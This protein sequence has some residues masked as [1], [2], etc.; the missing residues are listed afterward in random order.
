MAAE[1]LAVLE[2]DLAEVVMVINNGLLATPN[3]A[4]RPEVRQM[5]QRWCREETN[6]LKRLAE[7][8]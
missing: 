3:S 6:Y 2:R 7:D 8:K 1:I 4:I 5:L